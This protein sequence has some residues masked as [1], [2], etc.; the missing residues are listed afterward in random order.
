[1]ELGHDGTSNELLIMPDT[2]NAGIDL[3]NPR[4]SRTPIDSPTAWFSTAWKTL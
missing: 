3:L 1:V 4:N 2:L